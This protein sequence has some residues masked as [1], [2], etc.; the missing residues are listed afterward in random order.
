M[1]FAYNP[2]TRASL[3]I[4]ARSKTITN[5]EKFVLPGVIVH[6][7]GKWNRHTLEGIRLIQAK[8]YSQIKDIHRIKIA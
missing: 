6:M 7:T 4:W 2:Y 5:T 8:I 1:A 3:Q